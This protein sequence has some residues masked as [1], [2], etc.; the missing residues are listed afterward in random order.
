MAGD[1]EKSLSTELEEVV[2]L[3]RRH[4][5]TVALEPG[6]LVVPKGKRLS[7]LYFIESGCLEPAWSTQDVVAGSWRL[8]PGACLGDMGLLAGAAVA[9]VDLVCIEP[10]V[11]HE[12]S[13]EAFEAL[14]AREDHA[15]V[16]LYRYL[17]RSC[18]GR[19]TALQDEFTRLRMLLVI[20]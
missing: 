8:G 1:I 3:L 14:V 18:A 15:A 9:P 7:D 19:L 6:D 5:T 13:R 17:A 4:G 12:L 16:V 10:G 11:M 2:A 20:R